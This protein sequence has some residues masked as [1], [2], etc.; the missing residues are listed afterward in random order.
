MPALADT[1]T[2]LE[3]LLVHFQRELGDCVALSLVPSTPAAPLVA[4]HTLFHPAAIAGWL[5]RWKEARP[6]DGDP[7][8]MLVAPIDE[9]FK[10]APLIIQVSVSVSVSVSASTSAQTTPAA[11][12]N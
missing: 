8:Q 1:G 11:R 12:R 7:V 6:G 5:G 10:R 4:G 3:N 9:A 2:Q